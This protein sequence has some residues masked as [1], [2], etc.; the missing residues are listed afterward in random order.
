MKKLII[1]LFSLL[2]IG[3][4]HAQTGIPVKVVSNCFD[5]EVRAYV[6]QQLDMEND[7]LYVYVPSQNKCVG[8]PLANGT[9][10]PSGLD[11]CDSA[12]AIMILFH[13]GRYYYTDSIRLVSRI[14]QAQEWHFRIEESPSALK[15]YDSYWFA[16]VLPINVYEA[17]GRKITNGLVC[18][19]IT[20][21]NKRLY[22]HQG[23]R[24]VHQLRA[25]QMVAFQNTLQ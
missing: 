17:N 19:R 5:E 21:K 18:G 22:H 3:L 25:K 9:I 16:L 10:V 1:T 2:G 20:Y 6:A 15:T 8:L 11:G 13:K 23:K 12:R 7:T 14:R 24:L 4:C